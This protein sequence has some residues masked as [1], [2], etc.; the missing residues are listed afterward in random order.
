MLKESGRGTQWLGPVDKV[1]FHHKLEVM[2]SGVFSHRIDSL[3]PDPAGKIY[4][5]E[6]MSGCKVAELW[7][8]WC[9]NY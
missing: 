6:L 2:I 8:G 9:K 7:L 4:G 3:S 1:M 5:E